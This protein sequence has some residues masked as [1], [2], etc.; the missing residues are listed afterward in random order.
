MGDMRGSFL[1]HSRMA[2]TRPEE[3]PRMTEPRSS[4]S[5]IGA[6]YHSGHA[7][8]GPTDGPPAAILD[9]LAQL[10]ADAFDTPMALIHLPAADSPPLLAQYGL[11]QDELPEALAFCAQVLR[12]GEVLALAD[13]ALAPDSAAG[14]A[15]ASVTLRFCA[16]APLE[17]NGEPVGALCVFDTRPRLEG[18]SARQH[19]LLRNL[20][21]QVSSQVAPPRGQLAAF[22]FSEP[23]PIP[24]QAIIR[25]GP[26]GR[27]TSWNSAAERIFG[28]TRA[29]VLGRGISHLLGNG[30]GWPPLHGQESRTE[31]R[32]PTA[33]P[34]D[35]GD[36]QRTADY[37]TLLAAQKAATGGPDD[38]FAVWQ[39]VVSAALGVISA[40]E[41]ACVETVEG[42]ELVCRV[43]AGTC[44]PGTR[45]PRRGT[46]SDRS[47]DE[48]RVLLSNDVLADPRHD[49]A[50]YRKLAISSIITAPVPRRGKF[51]AVLKLASRR[52]GAFTEQDTALAQLLVGIMSAG[53]SNLAEERF[54]QALQSS[55]TR[56]R[57]M[58]DT[59]PQIVWQTNAEGK[60]DFLNRR[61]AEFTGLSIEEGLSG[62][63][64]L[65]LLH[66]DDV[67]PTLEAWRDAQ[68][69]GRSFRIN[70]R[71]R[72]ASGEY[73]WLL[74]VG[75]PHRDPRTGRI[76]RWFGGS[77]DVDAEYR[78]QETIRQLNDTLEQRVAER[79]R[80]RDRIWQLSRDML[81]IADAQGV[82][83]SVNPAWTRTLGWH[84]EELIGHQ[85]EWLVHPE[86]RALTRTEFARVARG[87]PSPHFENRFRTADGGYRWLSWSTAAEGGLLYTVVR[88]VTAEKEQAIALAQAEEQLRHSQKMEAVG[89]LT[90]G[91]AHDF[92]NLLAGIIAGLEM[93]QNRVAQQRFQELDRYIRLARGAADRA[94]ALTHRL[95]AFSRRQALDP[96][97]TDLNRLV[98]GI[99][100][101]IRRTVGP[102]ISVEITLA[103][104]LWLTHCDRNQLEN[105]LLNLCINARDAMPGGGRLIIG[106]ENADFRHG[107]PP[108]RE[109][110]PG[111][112]V[113]LRVTDTGT[114]M[115]PEVLARAFDPFYT[116]KPLGQ[117]TGLGLSMVYGFARQSGGQV[118]IVSELGRGTT[119]EIDLPRH[120]GTMDQ[121]AGEEAPLVGRARHHG[122]VLVVDDEPAI[123]TLIAEALR[124]VGHTV[125]EAADAAA[126]QLILEGDARV[127]LLLTD[128]GLPG[129]MNGRQLA[130]VARVRRPE[131]K[132]VFI[133]GYAEKAAMGNATLGPGMELMTKPFT[134]RNLAAKIQAALRR[135][136]R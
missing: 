88:D 133:T 118:R 85:P 124:E 51:V 13:V 45:M 125:L 84:E 76:L 49:A 62:T 94:A 100:E 10:A 47:L 111:Q 60:L 39:A 110:K 116:T 78:A 34:R 112:Y 52:P 9:A 28:L 108:E 98:P 30:K 46:L 35:N 38:E 117:G 127:D 130:D 55:E 115:P 69:P 74:T 126:A 99:E 77:T 33:P 107:R 87:E 21:A 129:G 63:R 83:L 123:R 48:G 3:S 97:P 32:S 8:T 18:L 66:P 29:E 91:L 41:S 11:C 42:D 136:R 31:V 40:A 135:S 65:D 120:F 20:A 1:Q 132:V 95:L 128:V 104:D 26:D 59:V 122:I 54:L 37:E 113:A 103:R 71:L 50:L 73:R 114:G 5:S 27:V 70:H 16:G 61:W 67:E 106:T 79:T 131:L 134:M 53:L 101:L 119:V 58:A 93:L 109:M 90:G 57:L 23:E 2:A 25:T 36:A 12:E 75:E 6:P 43:A 96:K 56:L 24:D 7:L 15:D 68:A 105:A 121:A 86:D 4:P 22:A 17:W 81:G 102:G 89:Q 14:P 92:N 44:T 80:E 72:H 64:M 19:R 82:L